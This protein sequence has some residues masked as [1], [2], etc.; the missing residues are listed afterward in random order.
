MGRVC[1]AWESAFRRRGHHWFHVGGEEVGRVAHPALFPRRAARWVAEHLDEPDV[2]LVHEPAGASFEQ[3]R[4]P[5]V[6]F[7]HGIERRGWENSLAFRAMSGE[8]VSLK[9]R[10]LY[11]LWR[12]RACDRALRAAHHVLVLNEEDRSYCMARYG[13]SDA[14]VSVI[15][16]GVRP[17]TIDETCGEKGAVT[18]LFLASWLPRKGI[19]TLAEA[20]AI[21][22]QRR[23]AL[24][25]LLAGTKAGKAEISRLW[26][27]SVLR[28]T[29]IIPE[30]PPESELDLYRSSSIFVLPSF[31]EGQPLALLQ[32]MACGRSCVATDGCGQ[33]D[34]I[35]HRVNGL[36]FTP[37]N[38]LELADRIE[39]C[40]ADPELRMALGREAR[41]SVE[42]RD[43]MTVSNSLVEKIE[44]VV[45]AKKASA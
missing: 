9:S 27:E 17:S 28:V 31:F 29:K 25:W 21:L 15:E 18:V 7:S 8:S 37:G 11:P 14:S 22:Q 4:T 35:R 16:N 26:P 41:R 1:S 30:F 2:Y 24:N 20:A 40:V 5:L 45:A 19:R 6:V 43:W 44:T 3:R 34:L 36:L 39:E 10:L 42:G 13:R 23:P 32:A 38:A 12:L 33:R